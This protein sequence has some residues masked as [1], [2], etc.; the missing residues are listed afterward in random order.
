MCFKI[1]TFVCHITG[2]IK[3]IYKKISS[4]P[5]KVSHVYVRWLDLTSLEEPHV[6]IGIPSALLFNVV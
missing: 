3:C 6:C 4:L 2:E 1:G 5:K